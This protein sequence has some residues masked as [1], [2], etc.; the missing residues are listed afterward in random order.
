[1][2]NL[3]ISSL[4]IN[5]YKVISGQGQGQSVQVQL[6]FLFPARSDRPSHHDSSPQ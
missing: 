6:I 1:M 4:E 2:E 3:I 5:E